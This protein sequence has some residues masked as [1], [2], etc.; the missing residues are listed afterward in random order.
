MIKHFV[1]LLRS[2]DFLKST[3]DEHFA[4]GQAAAFISNA[5][6]G[7]EEKKHFNYTIRKRPF[8]RLCAFAKFLPNHRVHSDSAPIHNSPN[9]NSPK[10]R[11]HSHKKK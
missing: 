2:G 11:A 1:H 3:G 6:T 5:S 7:S 8:K 4:F 10:H 9:L